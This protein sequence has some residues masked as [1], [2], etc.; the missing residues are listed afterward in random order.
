MRKKIIIGN[1]K[2]NKTQ[3][4]S[5]EFLKELKKLKVNSD[6]EFGVAPTFT[7]LS[8]VDAKRVK[9]LKL[10]AQNVSD[11]DNGAFTGEVSI[12]ML[13]E[14]N[15]EYVILGHSERREIFKED[16]VLIN[17]KTKHTLENGLKP[18]L[19]VGESLK[20][21]EAD[22]TAVVVTKQLKANLKDI[23]ANNVKKIV[24]AYEPIWAIGTGKTATAEQAQSVCKLIRDLIEKMYDKDTA[25]AIRIQYGGSVKPENVKEILGQDDID[26]ALVGGAS[27]DAKSFS[28][29][30]V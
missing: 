25:E 10:A 4:E 6:I 2:L 13:K 30:L 11:K 28:K 14:N 20:E 5:L 7:S 22:K 16:D 24:I 15:V 26:G 27:L 3:K 19:C 29:L 9:G 23:D 12:D 8:T 18:I 17:S 21:R 1:W